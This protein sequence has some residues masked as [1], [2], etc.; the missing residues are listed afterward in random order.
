[1]RTWTWKS[2]DEIPADDLMIEAVKA[3]LDE[4]MTRWNALDQEVRRATYDRDHCEGLDDYDNERAEELAHEEASERGLEGREALNWVDARLYEL[5]E[6]FDHERRD[7]RHKLTLRREVIEGLLDALGARLA[8]PY[9]HWGEEERVMQWL[10]E[11]RFDR[12]DDGY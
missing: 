5:L 3:Q 11:D 12:H 10:E 1:M 7:E 2:D 4:L 9:E 8:R 6:R